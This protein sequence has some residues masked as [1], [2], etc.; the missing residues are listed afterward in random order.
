MF[1]GRV[2]QDIQVLFLTEFRR[3][4]MVKYRRAN[5]VN[6]GYTVSVYT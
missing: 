1:H 4:E 3:T 5:G 6:C 2:I